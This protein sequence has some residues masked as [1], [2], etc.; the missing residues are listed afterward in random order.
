MAAKCSLLPGTAR[1][2]ASAAQAGAQGRGTSG[3]GACGFSPFTHAIS[4]VVSVGLTI[5]CALLQRDGRP[6][7]LVFANPN[8]GF[9]DCLREIVGQLQVFQPLVHVQIEL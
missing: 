4:Q 1:C 8:G 5:M 3:P 6:F 7:Q 2:A 9:E